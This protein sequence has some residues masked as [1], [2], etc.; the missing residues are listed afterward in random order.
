MRQPTLSY[1]ADQVRRHDNDRFICNLFAP[2]AEREALFA[3]HAFNL[4][5]SC[6]RERVRQ[7]LLGHVRLRWWADTLETIRAGGRPGGNQVAIALH[8]AA[9]R[10][11]IEWSLLHRIIQGRAMDLEDQAPE[12]LP[13]LIDYARET[14]ATL[15]LAGVQVVG[16][17]EAE[18]RAAAEDVGIAWAIVGL[19]RAVP[20]H[21]RARRLY[22]PADL[23]RQAGLDALAMFDK[24]ATAGISQVIRILLEVAEEH[25]RRARQRRQHVPVRALPVLLPAALANLYIR[26]LRATACNPFDPRVAGAGPDRLARVAFARLRRRY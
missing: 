25:L 23:N 5:I 3:L 9:N 10:F 20:Y 19:I 16:A 15:S 12:S 2:P 4:D 6:I 13:A 18:I 8:Q 24:G 14:S 26:R 17:D 1:C 22:L 11:G 21:A 7:P